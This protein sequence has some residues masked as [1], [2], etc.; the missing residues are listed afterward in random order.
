[1]ALTEL[2]IGTAILSVAK[3]GGLIAFGLALGLATLELVLQLLAP[4]LRPPLR[5]LSG[6][7]HGRSGAIRVLCAGDSHTFGLWVEPVESYPARLQEKLAGSTREFVILN[8]GVPGMN[9]SQLR[10]V[11]PVLLDNFSPDVVLLMVGVANFWNRAALQE[12]EMR[13]WRWLLRGGDLWE[14]SRV[15]KL[16]RLIHFNLRFGG[17]LGAGGQPVVDHFGAHWKIRGGEREIEGAH[18]G[19]FYVPLRDLALIRRILRRD[20]SSI[21]GAAEAR[22]VEMILMTYAPIVPMYDTVSDVLREFAGEFDLPLIDLAAELREWSV[23]PRRNTAFFPDSHPRA[24]GYQ[25]IA[26][27]VADALAR[28]LA[29][30]SRDLTDP[31]RISEVGD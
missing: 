8:A 22:G 18:E 19:H 27:V 15:V 1:L 24:A 31:E 4:I 30:E 11:F 17:S 2:R 23:Q 9:S 13:G 5:G 3:R 28:R 20:L 14:R 7:N 29:P 26:Q 12:R 6:E 25:L 21:V 16:A 10:D